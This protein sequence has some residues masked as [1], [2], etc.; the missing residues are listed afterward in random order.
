[1]SRTDMYSDCINVFNRLHDRN[2]PR[3]LRNVVMACFKI[4]SITS[5]GKLNSMLSATSPDLFSG[6]CCEEPSFC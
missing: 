2:R 3:M 4:I 5:D 1:M 6:E